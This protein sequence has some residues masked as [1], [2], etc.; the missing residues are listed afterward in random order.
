MGLRGEAELRVSGGSHDV[1]PEA[2][3]V[4][5]LLSARRIFQ[6]TG[7]M[8]SVHL[9]YAPLAALTLEFVGRQTQVQL[10]VSI[11]ELL[12]DGKLRVGQLQRRPVARYPQQNGG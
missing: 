8:L 12:L 11:T 1:A 2:R 5:R 9:H 4:D 6:E 10:P 7:R 3:K